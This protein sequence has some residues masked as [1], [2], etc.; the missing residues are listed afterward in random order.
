M[1]E[2]ESR[3]ALLVLDVFNTFQFPGGEELFNNATRVVDRVRLLRQ[4]FHEADCPVIFVNDNFERWQDSFDEVVAYVERSGERGRHMVQAL[5]PDASDLKLLKPRHSAFFETA[6]PSLLDHV[7]VKRVVVSGLAADSCVLST[8]LDAYVRRIDAVV[9]RDT[10]A[11]QSEERT[12]RT[13][14]LLRETFG[15]ATP[16]CGDIR[17]R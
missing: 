1:A 10:T 14:A 6:L 8:V 7:G 5:R 11:A 4:R 16:D 3:S 17:P 15:I 2:S 9:P 13:L 12:G